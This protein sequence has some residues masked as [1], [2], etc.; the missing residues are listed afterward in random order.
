MIV[1][2]TGGGGFV[3]GYLCRALREKGWNIKVIDEK[4]FEDTSLNKDEIEEYIQGDICDYEKISYAVK[5]VDLV[6]HLAARHRFFG[7]T[8]EEFYRVNVQGTGK[9]LEAMDEH[10]V[11][12]I[13]FYSSV[14]VYGEH[15]S[16]TTEEANTSPAFVYGITKLEAET[17]IK[18]WHQ[19]RKGRSALIIRPTVIFGPENRG[20]MYRLI[21]QID[22]HLFIPVGDGNNIKSTAYIENIIEATLFLMNRKEEGVEIYTY[23]DE[24]HLSFLETVRLIYKYLDR[25]FP[26]LKLPKGAVLA[27]L[28]PVDY[29]TN[30]LKIDL[31]FTAAI[32]KMNK[33]THHDA[34][35]IRE[36]G[37][38]QLF[39]IEEGLAR[40][41]DWYKNRKKNNNF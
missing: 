30:F 12:S 22:R 13:L 8:E 38:K 31:P 35:K 16:P 32:E 26:G 1:L 18:E 21:R 17:K 25:S 24:P 40:T 19:A 23:A 6:I 37:F 33:T 10:N 9:I 2:V 11:E 36:K 28:K 27:G 34:Q 3:G 20:N 4:P 29:I 41:V 15:D 7:I 5:G 39:S 14:A